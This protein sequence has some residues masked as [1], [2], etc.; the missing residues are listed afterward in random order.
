M[1]QKSSSFLVRYAAL[2]AALVW[3]SGCGSISDQTLIRESPA[4]TVYLQQFFERGTTMRYGGP[5]KSFR[6]NHPIT[7]T[8]EVLTK[9]LAGVHLGLTT[10]DGPTP[11]HGIKPR[12][13]F[14]PQDIAFLAPAVSEALQQAQPDQRVKFQVGTAGDTTDGILHIDGQA[15][16][17]TVS[18]YHSPV[19]Q[20]DDQLSV[21]VLS[22]I[23][24]EA[25]TAI[26][27]PQTWME[28]EPNQP[29]VAITL[30]ALS[31]LPAPALP[32]QSTP[33]T[34]RE[35]ADRPSRNEVQNT[36]TTLEKQAQELEALKAE[37]ETLKKQLGA[38]PKSP[39]K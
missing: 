19:S 5:V 35:S 26:T 30:S 13:V 18:H 31:P 11:V 24:H 34:T 9:A 7:L 29:R 36:K 38:Q 23:P 22:F 6:A 8:P 17:L 20:R 14:S 2:A 27:S 10:S 39:S 12:P 33:N 15:L 37:L 28:I 21:S 32:P 25:Q 16:H 4:G 1:P 3:V